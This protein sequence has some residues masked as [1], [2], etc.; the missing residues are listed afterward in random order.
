MRPSARRRAG[1]RLPELLDAATRLDR[2]V[3]DHTTSGATLRESTI[4]SPSSLDSAARSA[5]LLGFARRSPL[6]YDF[7]TTDS[8]HTMYR[9]APAA[10]ALSFAFILT[11]PTI[12]GQVFDDPG[13]NSYPACLVTYS[14]HNRNRQVTGA[15]NEECGPVIARI[16]HSPPFGNWGVDS[17][18]TT[19]YDG[20]QFPGWM[21]GD[22]W[23][24]WNSCTTGYG[25]TYS[26][27]AACDDLYND[28]ITSE[29]LCTTQT[30]TR[31]T[32]LHSTSTTVLYALTSAPISCTSASPGV[33][34]FHNLYMDVYELDAVGFLI[35]I[36]ADSDFVTT[37]TYPTIS[38]P[39]TCNH[40]TDTCSGSSG[41]YSHS[42]ISTP[43]TGVS[44][45]LRASVEIRPH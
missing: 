24:Q 27:P 42:S 29:G 36:H 3:A 32:A 25:G 26:A 18:Y 22:T 13:I 44:A 20:H 33:Q 41:W 15:V 8:D 38:V 10:L 4:A 5:T 19:L 14:F 6:V 7:T 12:S 39:L 16:G 35:P 9:Y 40:D 45:E 37:L 17:N 21:P 2:G 28:G 31:G 11:T 23:Y 30:T 43:D 1:R 34:I